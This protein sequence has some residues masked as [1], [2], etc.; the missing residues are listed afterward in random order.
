M[1]DELADRQKAIRVRLAGESIESR[2]M[3]TVLACL[4][5][6]WQ[7]LG[8]PAVVQ[9]D[10]G[11]EF[12]GWGHWPRSL[13]RVIRLCAPGNR[14]SLHPGRPTPA[15]RLGGAVQWLVSTPPAAPPLTGG[16]LGSVP[17]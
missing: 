14:A 11:K 9:F 5:H 4:V 8:L 2:D 1:H 3:D 16:D 10:N 7:C 17:P 13:S 12:C 15:Q 6:A